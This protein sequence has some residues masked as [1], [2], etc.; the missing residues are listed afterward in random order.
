MERGNVAANTGKG[1][2]NINTFAVLNKKIALILIKEKY[3]L[4]NVRPNR[5]E[6]KL[7]VW[8][9]EKTNEFE[10]RFF[11]L[12]EKNKL[13]NVEVSQ[14][15]NDRKQELIKSFKEEYS[16][17]LDEAIKEGLLKYRIF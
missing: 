17:L 8:I 13:H 1:E 7:M 10:K 14:E 5:K 6:P 12:S 2:I 9:F 11:E 4:I 16:Q 15:F 3:N